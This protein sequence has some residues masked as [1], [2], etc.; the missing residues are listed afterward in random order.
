MQH[1]YRNQKAIA[2]KRTPNP[3]T[4]GITSLDG[5]FETALDTG[6]GE[7]ELEE[8]CGLEDAED[9]AGEAVLMDGVKAIILDTDARPEV[10]KGSVGRAELPAITTD[11]T[12]AIG[13]VTKVWGE[14]VVVA[15]VVA[16]NGHQK[17]NV[18]DVVVGFVGKGTGGVSCRGS[19]CCSFPLSEN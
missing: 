12:G 15:V 18:V 6:A 5:G 19:T 1:P 13:T 2:S 16:G 3:E 14:V 11:A 17:S 10:R 7:D 4:M 9:E 8:D